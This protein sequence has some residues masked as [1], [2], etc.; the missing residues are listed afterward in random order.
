M[1]D[2]FGQVELIRLTTPADQDMDTVQ[3]D[4]VLRAL[5]EASALIDGYL[6]RR[7]QVPLDLVPA[8]VKRATCFLARYDLSQGENKEPSEQVVSAR[9]ETISWLT[10]VSKG[11]VLLP[12]AE[13]APGDNSFARVQTRGAAWGALDPSYQNF[14]GNQP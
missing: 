12:L 14:P 10:Q 9:K 11:E 4:P 2:R 8:E 6:R 3:A 7:Y 1:V 13:V 5:D